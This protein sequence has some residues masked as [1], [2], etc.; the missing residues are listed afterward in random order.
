MQKPFHR[1]KKLS[2]VSKRQVCNFLACS[3]QT[4]PF[5]AIFPSHESFS[6]C[7]EVKVSLRIEMTTVFTETCL[8][9]MP[10]SSMRFLHVKVPSLILR[11]LRHLI[12]SRFSLSLN[13]NFGPLFISLITRMRYKRDIKMGRLYTPGG[14]VIGIVGGGV[15]FR[16]FISLITRMRYKRDIKMGRLCTP[17]GA[18]IGIVGG[19]VTFRFF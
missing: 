6:P 12:S 4:S 14:A 9:S 1:S 16:F 17:G 15:T 18:V 3:L 2:L 8:W 7:L 19:G 10:D 11:I 13:L 5:T